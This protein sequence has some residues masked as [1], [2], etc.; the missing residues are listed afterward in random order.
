MSATTSQSWLFGPRTDFA[1]FLGSALASVALCL[2]GPALGVKSDTPLWAWVL[3]VVCIDVAHVW[4]TLFRVYLDSDELKRRPGLYLAA[5]L[6]A[7]IIGVLAYQVSARF[8]WSLFAYTAVW[9]FIRQQVGFMALYGRRAQLSVLDVKL[10]SAAVYAATLLP[11]VWWHANLPRP[12][13][14]FV[15]N[16]F[17]SGLPREVGT[18]AMALHTVVLGAWLGR[19]ILLLFKRKSSPPGRW[20]LLAATWAVWFGGIV[21]AQNDYVFTVM[22]VVL[23]GV[24]YF[25]LLYI[26]ARNRWREGGYGKWGLLVRA[27]IPAFMTFL[28]VLAFVEELL[29]DKLVW[30][31]RPELFGQAGFHLPPVLLGLVVPLLALPQATH[32]VLDGFV[33]RT[34]EDPALSR[35]IFSKAA[36]SDA[37]LEKPRTPAVV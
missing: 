16:D 5:P 27:G 36:S 26:Y 9:H 12:F 11:V 6:L 2:L 24:P 19:Q 1:V 32:Y 28:I 23:H 7:F 30:H 10:D 31:E 37:R 8:F 3:L 21:W 13:W 18:A 20:L 34:R 22:N 4:S 17:V 29:W 33:W 14:W 35:R 15:E 25:A